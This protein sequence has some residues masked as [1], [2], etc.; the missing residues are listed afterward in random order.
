MSNQPI[1]RTQARLA[2]R[3]RLRVQQQRNTRMKQL[4]PFAL[5]GIVLL[6]VVFVALTTINQTTGGVIG[7]RIQ[8]DRDEIDLGNQPFDRTVRAMFTVKNVGDGTLKLEAPRLVT[9][10]EGC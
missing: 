3:E 4:I 1:R 10:L 6:F 2:A 8:I 5:G 7:A 9:A